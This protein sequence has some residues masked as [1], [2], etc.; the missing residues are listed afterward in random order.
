MCFTPSRAPV[1][2]AQ[3]G[4]ELD[5]IRSSNH[6]LIP[7][8]EGC[9]LGSLGNWVNPLLTH[10]GAGKAQSAWSRLVE[11]VSVLSVRPRVS[12]SALWSQVSGRQSQVGRSG[13]HSRRVWDTGRDNGRMRRVFCFN[14]F[15]SSGHL[16]MNTFPLLPFSLRCCRARATDKSAAK[17]PGGQQVDLAS[18]E[19]SASKIC[20]FAHLCV[21]VSS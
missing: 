9:W 20:A 14:A 11:L 19:V 8:L 5:E 12:Q 7:Q 17:Q 10:G 1:A 3:P 16:T 4:H 13:N 18:C 15:T 2:R 6:K 21:C